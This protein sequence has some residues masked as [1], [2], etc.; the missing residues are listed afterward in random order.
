MR[1]RATGATGAIDSVTIRSRTIGSRPR[2]C[3]MIVR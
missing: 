2:P 1:S 3:G